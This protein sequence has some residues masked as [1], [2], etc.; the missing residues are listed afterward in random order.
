MKNQKDRLRK[1]S[2]R[3]TNARWPGSL[4]MQAL[5]GSVIAGVAVA[6]LGVGLGLH[7]VAASGSSSPAPSDLVDMGGS[8]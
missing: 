6:G 7:A 5:L 4:R 3:P 2:G 8:S 1:G